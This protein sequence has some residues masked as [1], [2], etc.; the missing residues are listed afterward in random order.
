MILIGMSEQL[1]SDNPSNLPQFP[2]PQKALLVQGPLR[3]EEKKGG[4]FY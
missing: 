3:E 1:P 2:K 4:Q